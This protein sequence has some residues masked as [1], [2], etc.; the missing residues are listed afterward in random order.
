MMGGGKLGQLGLGRAMENCTEP[1][2]VH[3]AGGGS[4]HKVCSGRK[5]RVPR[6][7]CLCF[8]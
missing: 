8:L 3:V 1:K 6:T 4:V 7:L 2:M 5:K